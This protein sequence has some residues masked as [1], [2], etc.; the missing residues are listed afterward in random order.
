MS[1]KGEDGSLRHTQYACSLIIDYPVTVKGE[2]GR[3]PGLSHTHAS[4]E[5]TSESI[6]SCVSDRRDRTRGESSTDL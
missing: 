2:D 5:N 3:S 4:D 1:V 6:P